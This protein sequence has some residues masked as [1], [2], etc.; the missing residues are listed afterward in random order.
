MSSACVC[1]MMPRPQ[2]EELYKSKPAEHADDPEELRLLQHFKQNMGDYKLKTASDYI[3]PESQRVSTETKRRQLLELR[4][5][6]CEQ[7]PC[8]L[9]CFDVW[10]STLFP[11]CRSS[12]ASEATTPVSWSCVTARLP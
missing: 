4:S 9:Q 1:V 2:W 5:Q 7:A 12:S 3:V 6:V 10:R 8:P 11:L